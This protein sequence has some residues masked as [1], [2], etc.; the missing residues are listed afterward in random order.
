MGVWWEDLGLP[1][2]A[3]LL[4]AEAA[5]SGRRGGSELLNCGFNRRLPRSWGSGR[6]LGARSPKPGVL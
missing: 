3:G 1:G 6:K 2:W 4:Q 5:K